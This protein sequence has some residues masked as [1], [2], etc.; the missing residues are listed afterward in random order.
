MSGHSDDDRADLIASAA[1]VAVYFAFMLMIAFLPAVL[2]RRIVAWSP[3]SL[4]LVCG[5]AVTSIL[6]A[7][8][9]IYTWR[10]NRN[11]ESHVSTA[12]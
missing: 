4:G 8:A 9:I 12:Q 10:R 6:V 3:M 1:V 7:A 11:P 2:S 5:I